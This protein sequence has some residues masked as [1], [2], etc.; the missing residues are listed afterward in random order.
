MMQ[1]SVLDPQHAYFIKEPVYSTIAIT[2][3]LLGIAGIVVL[4]KGLTRGRAS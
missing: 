4:L 1:T 2:A 3:V